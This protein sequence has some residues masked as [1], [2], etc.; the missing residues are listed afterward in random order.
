MNVFDGAVFDG[1]IVFDTGALVVAGGPQF[2]GGWVEQLVA[3]QGRSRTKEELREERE[4]LGILPRRVAQVIQKIAVQ[5][6][7]EPTNPDAALHRA[8]DRLHLA[9]RAYYAE[10]LRKQIE[11]ERQQREDEEVLLLLMH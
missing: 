1:P 5:Q 3:K 4:R 10:V 11:I 9:Y 7:Q 6:V 8:L 2:G